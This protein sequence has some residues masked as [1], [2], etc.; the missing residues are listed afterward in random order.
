MFDTF[1]VVRFLSIISYVGMIVSSITGFIELNKLPG[2]DF[3]VCFVC[4]SLVLL[5]QNLIYLTMELIRFYE[6]FS[7]TYE[8]IYYIRSVIILQSSI[9]S[10]GISSVGLGFG[11]FG[12]GNF[13]INILTGV[14]D[15]NSRGLSNLRDGYKLTNEDS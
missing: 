10:I 9:L 7:Y 11:I 2:A 15:D 4:T 14:F 3:K 12:I 8:K 13:L 1:S 6:R 5:I